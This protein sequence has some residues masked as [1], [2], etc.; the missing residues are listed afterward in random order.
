VAL[1]GQLAQLAAAAEPIVAPAN[2][3][4]DLDL[5]AEPV[6]GF[7]ALDS[8]LDLGTPAKGPVHVEPLDIDLSLPEIQPAVAPS[9][10]AAE[11][12][13]GGLD[14]EFDLDAPPASSSV[15]APSASAIDFSGINLDLVTA[16]PA[17]EEVK[18]MP[19]VASAGV[20]DSDVATKL[21]LAQAY[22]EMGDREGARELLQEVAQE[23]SSQQ[24]ELARTRLA[25]L[26]A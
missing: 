12:G 4:F 10:F 19:E 9:A 18:E 20:D 1:P 25:A 3:G 21:E 17:F 13:S 8:N 11:S 7:T 22:E 16:S 15:A 23:G 14:F 6:T 24:Q 2:L 26:D 5:G